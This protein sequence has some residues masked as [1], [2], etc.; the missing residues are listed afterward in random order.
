[1]RVCTLPLNLLR[2]LIS[3]NEKFSRYLATMLSLIEVSLTLALR[4]LQPRV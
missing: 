4:V 2:L 1:M 3:N